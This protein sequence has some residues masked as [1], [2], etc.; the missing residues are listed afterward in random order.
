MYYIDKVLEIL[1]K[2]QYEGYYV[3]MAVAWAISVC[4]IKFPKETF[5]LLQENSLDDFTYNKALQKI[6]ESYRVSEEEKKTI[7]AMKRTNKE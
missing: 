4:Y 2:I 3:K 5:K 6:I 7:R 1:N